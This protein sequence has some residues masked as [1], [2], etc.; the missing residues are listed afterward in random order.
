MA[1]AWARV[2][3]T[4]SKS[5]SARSGAPCAPVAR[6][7]R[8]SCGPPGGR[9]HSYCSAWQGSCPSGTRRV[10]RRSPISSREHGICAPVVM[11]AVPAAIDDI[12]ITLNGFA[13]RDPIQ[14]ETSYCAFELLSAIQWRST[15]QRRRS[16]GLWEDW[17]RRG[18]SNL[19][20]HVPKAGS[21]IATIRNCRVINHLDPAHQPK[22]LEAVSRL[23]LDHERPWQHPATESAGSGNYIWKAQLG[24][25]R[26][27]NSTQSVS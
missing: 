25:R 4:G 12:T 1:R 19:R 6:G 14:G 27:E 9:C 23:G 5:L 16:L 2:T 13:E 24:L 15:G 10:A 11:P 26:T 3:I 22:K 18:D 7:H 17:S 20:P 21:Q 8:R